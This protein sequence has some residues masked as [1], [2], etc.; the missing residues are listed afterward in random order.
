MVVVMAM[1]RR[2]KTLLYGAIAF[3]FCVALIVST[4]YSQGVNPFDPDTRGIWAISLV[5]AVYAS[6]RGAMIFE[7]LSRSF[8]KPQSSSGADKPRG[9]S[10]FKNDH[11]IDKRM[12][13]RRARVEAAKARATATDKPEDE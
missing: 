4:A 2:K 10:L 3:V 5:A 12:A 9:F 7:R 1:T 8:S 11:A 13:A 6:F